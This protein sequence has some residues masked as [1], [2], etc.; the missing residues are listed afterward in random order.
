MSLVDKWIDTE[1][2]D[3][4]RNDQINKISIRDV[5]VKK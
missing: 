5:K 3:L 1:T 2:N 4:R